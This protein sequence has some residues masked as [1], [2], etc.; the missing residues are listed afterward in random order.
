MVASTGATVADT[1]RRLRLEASEELLKQQRSVTE[2]A[3]ALG[4]GTP[5]SY[6][7]AFRRKTGTSPT[8]HRSAVA[9][10]LAGPR[11]MPEVTLE[12]RGELLVVAL[13]RGSQFDPHGAEDD[14]PAVTFSPWVRVDARP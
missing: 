4:F 6:A 14:R 1:V 9:D 2:T 3:M 7:R 13:R 8:E 11:R 5:Q 12:Y 10:S